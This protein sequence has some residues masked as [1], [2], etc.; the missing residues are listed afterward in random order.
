MTD[1]DLVER[2]DF[3]RIKSSPTA[4]SPVGIPGN[5]KGS[6]AANEPL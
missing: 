4:L 2:N 6:L 1:R 5:Y 3:S